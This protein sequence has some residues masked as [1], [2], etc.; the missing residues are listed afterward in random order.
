MIASLIFTFRKESNIIL[1]QS[2]R[3]RVICLQELTG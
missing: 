2:F 1:L 3:S